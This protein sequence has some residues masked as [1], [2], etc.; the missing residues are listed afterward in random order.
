MVTAVDALNDILVEGLELHPLKEQRQCVRNWR[1]IGL[2]IMGLAD[3]L[4]K[5]KIRYGSQKAIDLCEKIAKTLIQTAVDESAVTARELT[6]YPK[7]D[8]NQILN[9]S[10]FKNLDNNPSLTT[11][12]EKYGLFNS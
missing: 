4:I 5:M 3:M 11:L 8:K 2:G 10:F 9:T 7:C 6:M 1:Q 12:I